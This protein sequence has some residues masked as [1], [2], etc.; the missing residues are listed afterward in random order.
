MKTR[1]IISLL[2]SSALI[3]VVAL[4]LRACSPAANAPADSV[5]Q[6]LVQGQLQGTIQAIQVQTDTA[7]QVAATVAAIVSNLA[8]ATPP[9]TSVPPTSPPPAANPEPTATP[10]PTATP[11]VVYPTAAPQAA[12][13]AAPQT[14]SMTIQADV[15]TNCR[16]GPSTVYKVVGYL[17]LGQSS[18]VLGR[19]SSNSWWYIQNPSNQNSTCW[20]WSGS[21]QIQGDVNALAVTPV[22]PNAKRAY[23]NYY[24]SY[25]TSYYPRYT[26]PG[27]Y[28]PGYYYP[29][30][31]YPGNYSP[32]RYYTYDDNGYQYFWGRNGSFKVRRWVCEGDNCYWA[33]DNL[34][35]YDYGKYYIPCDSPHPNTRRVPRTVGVPCYPWVGDPN[36]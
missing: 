13:A 11:E 18:T 4:G 3:I 35:N 7:N 25:N 21:T 24:S 23:V 31:Y 10:L 30:Y 16:T 19:T 6:T 27:Y 32:N 33:I 9:P 2:G 22:D 28:Y 14:A 12:I 34:F 15:N 5:V 20:V 29:G 8:T 36:P 17:M 26:S 1:R